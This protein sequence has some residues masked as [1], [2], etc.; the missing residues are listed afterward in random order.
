MSSKP[1]YNA[2]VVSTPKKAGEKSFWADV[3]SVWPH[4][5]GSGFDLVIHEGVSVHGR[6]VCIERKEN[7]PEV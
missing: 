7:D 4:K 1:K 3:G 2:F 6:I 5:K